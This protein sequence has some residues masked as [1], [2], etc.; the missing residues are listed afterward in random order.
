MPSIALFDLDDTLIDFDSDHAWGDYLCRRGKV[1]A[2]EYHAVNDRFFADYRAGRLD[3]D[4]FLAFSLRPL[5]AI[6]YAELLVLREDFMREEA[7]AR[8]L[9]KARE[10]VALHRGAG[11]RCAIITATNRFVTEPFAELF[12]VDALL[13]TDIET[14]EGRP[15][16]RPSG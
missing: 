6:P 8:I 1:D 9:P 11:D 13:A 2:A 7:R 5:A 15:T 12:G 4:A 10:L 16:G 14:K 3:M